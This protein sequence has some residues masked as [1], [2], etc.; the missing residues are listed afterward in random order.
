MV[1]RQY[2]KIQAERDSRSTEKNV[3]GND[4]P[5]DN[6]FVDFTFTKNKSCFSFLS[7]NN[8]EITVE[9]NTQNSPQNNYGMNKN[10]SLKKQKKS[11]KHE[12][13]KSSNQK[14]SEI[15]SNEVL[16]CLSMEKKYFNCENEIS[17]IF[18]SEIIDYN[19]RSIPRRT[20]QKKYLNMRHFFVLGDSGWPHLNREE[21][22]IRMNFLE[23]KKE[24][25]ISFDVEY[26][27]K[28]EI[29]EFLID[30]MLS[31]EIYI[32]MEKNP[33]FFKGLI[34][35]A[36]INILRGE[37]EK[38]FNYIQKALYVFE[39]SLHPS[40]SPF[41]Y[42]DGRPNTLI[43]SG[44]MESRDIFVMFGYYMLYLGNRG[45]FRTALQY[46]ILLISMDIE[47]DRFHSLLHVDYYSILSS[48]FDILI[49]INDNFLTQF[50]R[51]CTWDTNGIDSNS[52]TQELTCECNSIIPLYYI[53][54]NFAFGIPLA[55][56]IINNKS[57]F[58]QNQDTANIYNSIQGITIDKITDSKFSSKNLHDCSIYLIQ[59]ILVF[60]EFIS[61]LKDS[62]DHFISH[63]P[64][65]WND[66]YNILMK[67]FEDI[68]V[69]LGECDGTNQYPYL[70]VGKL[71]VEA[72]FEK[73]KAI[74]KKPTNTKWL[75]ACC[76]QICNILSENEENKAIIRSFILNRRAILLG[77]RF[78]VF[79]YLDVTKSE[80]S[81]DSTLPSFF[82]DEYSSKKI[83]LGINNPNFSSSISLNSDPITNYFFSL[84]PWYGIDESSSNLAPVSLRDLV[85]DSLLTLKNYL[86]RT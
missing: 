49:G 70:L 29:L 59:S 15:E 27:K 80:F 67:L 40:F 10:V 66:I 68:D 50:Y 20:A 82:R 52:S 9:S 31:D 55:F 39:S 36:E 28:K 41:K 42:V 69:N 60:P 30:S 37:P 85:L 12:K 16:C 11:R 51:Y 81:N 56:F 3:S 74:W 76:V 75:H 26:L 34:K 13:S 71:L 33:F 43:I 14:S 21:C 73:C 64:P 6:S 45:L 1:S 58:D 77:S 72:Y 79:R 38:A 22:G 47:H 17:S 8:D 84:L 25:S 35:L 83:N 65:T 63:D 5:H 62:L 19:K 4:E 32:F 44:E 57:S 48:S 23:E 78:N 54:P 86:T 2:K 46:C 24:F 53:L 61:L 18:G 7:S